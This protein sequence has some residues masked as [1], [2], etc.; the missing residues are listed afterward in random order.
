MRKNA[1]SILQTSALPL[2]YRAASYPGQM[3]GGYYGLVK[4][5]DK[6]FRRSMKTKDRKLA[7]RQLNEP[8]VPSDS[9]Q[10]PRSDFLAVMKCEDEIR[11]AATLSSQPRP[12][13]P[14]IP[15]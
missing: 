10:H 6:Q 3:S 7:E 8:V 13:K 12:R 11:P 14:R 5:G 9:G 15:R 2:G 4:R 1:F